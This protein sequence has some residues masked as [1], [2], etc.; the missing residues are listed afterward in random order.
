MASVNGSRLQFSCRNETLIFSATSVWRV[1]S[2]K[3]RAN[4]RLSSSCTLRSL[5]ERLCNSAVRS[6]ITDSS[7]A[8]ESASCL[9]C[10]EVVHIGPPGSGGDTNDSFVQSSRIVPLSAPGIWSKVH[11]RDEMRTLSQSVGSRTHRSAVD[12]LHHPRA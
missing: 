11:T 10:F 6:K 9:E 2:C 12:R 7:W 3:S 8:W 1:L 5:W 4:L